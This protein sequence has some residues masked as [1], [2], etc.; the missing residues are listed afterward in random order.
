MRGE[1]LEEED[2]EVEEEERDMVLE[3]AWAAAKPSRKRELQV[4]IM[5]AIIITMVIIL[6]LFWNLTQKCVHLIPTTETLP[7]FRAQLSFSNLNQ[8]FPSRRRF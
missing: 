8:I 3:D 7:F 5:A 6:A 4:T 1:G 2:D